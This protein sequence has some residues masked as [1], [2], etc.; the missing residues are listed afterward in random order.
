ML[1]AEF[2]LLSSKKRNIRFL[3][4]NHFMQ[5]GIVDW[6]LLANLEML[7]HIKFAFIVLFIVEQE[8]RLA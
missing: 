2:N 3:V 8:E 6:V 7:Q 4:L 1:G 5:N